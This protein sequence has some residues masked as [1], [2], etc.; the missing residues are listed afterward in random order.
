MNEALW[1]DKIL[2][3]EDENDRLRAEVK[4]WKTNHQE[5]RRRFLACEQ[6]L[7][8]LQQGDPAQYDGSEE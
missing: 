4:R 2:H 5:E 1:E 7:K 8:R 3:L 6:A